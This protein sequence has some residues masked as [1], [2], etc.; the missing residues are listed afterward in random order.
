MKSAES[1][2]T[3]LENGA[4][5]LNLKE[6]FLSLCAEVENESVASSPILVS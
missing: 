6:V 2:Q 3:Y 4:S 5:N 1:E